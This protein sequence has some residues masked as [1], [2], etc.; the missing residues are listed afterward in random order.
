MLILHL[1][2]IFFFFSFFCLLLTS[3]YN[4]HYISKKHRKKQKF[5]ITSS[6]HST[7]QTKTKGTLNARP[8]EKAIKRYV[9]EAFIVIVI[10]APVI[11]LCVYWKQFIISRIYKEIELKPNQKGYNVWSKPPIT[12][13]RDYYLFNITNPIE[14]VTKPAS[15]TVH[16]KE[17]PPY[18]Y[19]L[20]STKRDIQW[21]NDNTE[22]SYSIYRVF[23]RHPTKF[24]WSSVNDTGTFI[25][26]VR[27]IFRTQFGIKPAPSFYTFAGMN[28]F[29]HRNAV[30]QLEGFTSEL[31][32]L[33][34][35]KLTGPNTDKSGFIYRYN[36]SRTYNFTIKAGMNTRQKSRY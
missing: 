8:S 29:Y 25:D 23:A 11:V 28:P 13:T 1:R 9:F 14:I 27:A 18:S 36:G 26:F 16:V 33:V 30:E 21:S 6:R 35:D 3:K 7:M 5:G 22:I 4:R 32:D 24:D 2:F 20:S 31:F 19:L 10:M 17:M 34:R 12:I 15:T